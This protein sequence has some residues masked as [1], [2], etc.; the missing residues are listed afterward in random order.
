[1]NNTENYNKISLYK[2]YV[3]SKVIHYKDL[4][5]T[6]RYFK[7]PLFKL[8]NDLSSLEKT[9]GF[10]LYERHQKEFTLTTEGEKFASFSKNM[11]NN[12]HYIAE[13][14]NI[15][16]ETLTIA[17]YHGVCE[18]ILPQALAKFSRRHP[19]IRLRVLAGIEHEDFTNPEID[20]S[21]SSFLTNRSDLQTNH[22]DTLPFYF[23]ASPDYIQRYGEPMT[24][25]DMENH[26]IILFKGMEYR[27]EYKVKNTIPH[28]ETT[29]YDLIYKLLLLG[30]GIAAIPNSRLQ[31]SDLSGIKM[32]RVVSG[33]KCTDFSIYFLTRRFSKKAALTNDFLDNIKE[34][35]NDLA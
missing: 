20:I 6:A 2:Y 28:I 1:M 27:S 3:F 10:N 32:I 9:L 15:E 18:R 5:K 14:R 25:E 33:R 26:K 30:C 23:Y 12:F 8:K 31:K 19:K 13:K 4:L 7:I 35:L 21:I 29:N 16:E 11:V 17:A 22:L 34:T 24:Y